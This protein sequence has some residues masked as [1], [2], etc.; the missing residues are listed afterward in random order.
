LPGFD[1]LDF[2]PL[3]TLQYVVI[4]I[5]EEDSAARWHKQHSLT[6]SEQEDEAELQKLEANKAT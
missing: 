2:N 1:P 5:H 6:K 4:G 3:A